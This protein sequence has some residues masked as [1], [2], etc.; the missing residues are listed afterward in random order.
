[1]DVHRVVDD[2]PAELGGDEV[3]IS[4]FPPDELHARASVFGGGLISGGSSSGS[5]IAV[6][7]GTVAFA[8]GTDTAGSGRVPAALDG[9]D[10]TLALPAR[11]LLDDGT[12]VT[13]F[14]CEAY[15][16]PGARDITASGGWRNHR[17]G[18]T[19]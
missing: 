7:D 4:T 6:A 10:D 5:A 11:S 12:E 8:L 1:V 16:T 18:G 13:G 2:V 9:I 17:L 14:L 19:H 3:W 15:A